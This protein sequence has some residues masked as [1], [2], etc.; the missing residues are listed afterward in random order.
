M[1]KMKNK[2]SY[3]KQV[4]VSPFNYYSKIFTAAKMVQFNANKTPSTIFEC[5]KKFYLKNPPMRVMKK[6]E[7]SYFWPLLLFLDM[8]SSRLSP[9]SPSSQGNYFHLNPMVSA[10]VPQLSNMF[11]C[12]VR[13]PFWTSSEKHRCLCSYLTIGITKDKRK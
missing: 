8:I 3:S 5:Q 6:T 13:P 4:K 7:S 12:L 9:I 11:L 10:L 2:N 1:A